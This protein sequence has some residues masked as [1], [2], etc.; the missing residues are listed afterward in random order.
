MVRSKS[1]QTEWPEIQSSPQLGA[2]LENAGVGQWACVRPWLIGAWT[3]NASGNFFKQFDLSN[4]TVQLHC[5]NAQCGGRRPYDHH[6]GTLFFWQS[7]GFSW[8]VVAYKCRTCTVDIQLFSVLTRFEEV[9]DEASVEEYDPFADEDITAQ[10]DWKGRFLIMK[11]GQVPPRG[12]PLPPI[13]RRAAHNAEVED[14]LEKGFACER[15]SFGVGAFGYYRRAFETIIPATLRDIQELCTTARD[16][17]R[18]GRAL[19]AQTITDSLQLAAASLPSYLKFE[20]HNPLSALYS[21]LSEGIHA[22]G[23]TDEECLKLA[24]R[25]LIAMT[26]VL[27]GIQDHSKY[28]R[29]AKKALSDIAAFTEQSK[30]DKQEKRLLAQNATPEALLSPPIVGEDLNIDS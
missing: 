2:F 10:K 18:I 11:F 8:S 16:K 9:V 26:L 27:G 17:Q 5:V 25:A 23:P 22:E 19:N 24:Q 3:K 13:L 29:E 21:A 4:N 28:R 14:L 7:G 6:S 12:G 30:K 20:S 1:K 15:H